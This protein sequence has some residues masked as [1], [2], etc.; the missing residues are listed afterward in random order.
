[1]NVETRLDE[2]RNEYLRRMTQADSTLLH[3]VETYTASHTGKMLRPRILLMSAATL[4]N[5]HLVSHRTLLLATCVEMLHNAS[6]LHDD[7][8]DHA[9]SRRGQPSVNARWN[10]AIA[11]L[12]GDYHL[13]QIMQLLSELNDQETTTK[14][15]TVVRSMVEA[16][17]LAQ[18]LGSQKSEVGDNSDLLPQTTY[19]KI[20][21]GKTA[22]L[23]AL[24]AELGNPAYRTF[25]LHYGRLFQLR[26][27]IADGEATPWTAKLIKEEEH[28]IKQLDYI[29]NI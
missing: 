28:A 15:N 14:V 9:T 24:A 29:L 21:D 17:L 26:D 11:V 2:V 3:Q 22:N 19:L 8:I 13:T 20:I 5:D 12:V 4:G 16:E 7:V 1:M 27:D 10:N 25:G 6:L 18:E 23:F